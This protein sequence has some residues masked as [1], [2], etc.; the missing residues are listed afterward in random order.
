[1]PDGLGKRVAGGIGFLGFF[2]FFLGVLGVLGII[3][4]VRAL[5]VLGALGARRYRFRSGTSRAIAEYKA[6]GNA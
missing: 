1:M 6:G 3:R 2:L 4:A 5:G